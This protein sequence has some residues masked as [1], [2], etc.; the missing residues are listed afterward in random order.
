MR[1]SACFLTIVGLSLNSVTAQDV[2]GP[3]AAQPKRSGTSLQYFG[4]SR[5]TESSPSADA[6]PSSAPDA[7]QLPNY[8]NDLFGQAETAAPQAPSDSRTRLKPAAGTQFSPNSVEATGVVQAG[9][10]SDNNAQ[11][12]KIQQVRAQ[13]REARPFPGQIT[14]TAAE[15]IAQ[16]T[17]TT[18]IAVDTAAPMVPATPE[19][20]VALPKLD[21]EL[22]A[23]TAANVSF[24]SK[25][26]SVSTVNAPTIAT[27]QVAAGPQTPSVSIEWRQNSAVNVGQESSCELVVKNTGDVAASGVEVEAYFP[28]IV[29]LLGAVPSPTK[30]ETFLGW[31]FAMLKPGEEKVI[32]VKMLPLQRGSIETRA[33][34]RFT[35]TATH[36]FSVAEP[37]LAVNL[38][39]PKQV[40]VGDSAPQTIVVTNPGNGVASNVQIEAVIPEGLEH[41]RGKRLLMDIGSLNPGESRN[42]RLAIAAV[43]GG[44]HVVQVQAR[45]DAG[46]L[47]NAVAEVSVMAP[48]LTAAIDGPGLR[49]IG[50]QGTFKL[51]VENDGAAATSNVQVMHKVPDGFDFVSA[52]RGVQYDPATR[53]M[54]W[55]VGRLEKGAKSEINVTLTARKPGMHKH[56]VRATSE[57]GSLADAEFMSRVEGTSSLSIE[58]VD[59]DDPVELGTE[60]M[61]EVRVKNEG[62]AAARDVG[63]TCELAPGVTFAGAAGPSQHIAENGNVIFRTIPELGPG[64]TAVYRVKVQSSAAG[65]TRFRAR[66]TSES[67][68]EALTADELT[69]FYGE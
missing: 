34:V 40:M 39:G 16:P 37:L 69:K 63:V 8:Y 66:V 14:P 50:R 35:G 47:Q 53:L 23:E 64:K 58:V 56:L 27:P 25:I 26:G 19:T 13:R 17:L 29:R 51:S 5:P 24:T 42:I 1:R 59:L 44:S 49:F 45:A 55:F 30:S 18:P 36:A 28:S 2:F 10:E 12:N 61:Y 41:A 48:S 68:E 6:A 3:S 33:N 9:F 43:A 11:E 38:Q 65:N 62:S 57:H 15:R 7:E 21:S 4:S 22:S 31:Q 54:T 20:S 52:D 32:S 67:V 60:A 46:L